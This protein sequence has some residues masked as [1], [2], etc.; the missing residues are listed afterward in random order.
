MSFPVA[1]TAQ[2]VYD[3]ISVLLLTYIMQ[4]TLFLRKKSFTSQ[5]MA[6]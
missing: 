5:L 6:R 1:S 3:V 2:D 4:K